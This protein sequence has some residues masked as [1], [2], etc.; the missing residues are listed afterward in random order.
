MKY[1][2]IREHQQE[3]S[4]LV[5]CRVLK[6]NRSGFYAWL[7]QQLSNRAIENS[8]LLARIK[9]F[10]V[11]SGG[12]YG[13]PW[14]HRDLRE[15][16]ESCSVNGVAKIMQ[17]SSLRAQIGYKC[18]YITGSKLSI[19]ADN[20]L[21][22]DF[23]PNR[24]NTVWVSDITYVRTYEGFLY[25]ATVIDLFSRRVVGWS[26]DKNMD[27][28][29]VIGALLMTVYQRRPRGPVLMHSD[30]GSQYGGSVYLLSWKSIT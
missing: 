29:L 26:M 25:L 12:T 6:I 13:S 18:G 30:Q 9:E 3:F 10:Y 4:V 21:E 27:K 16:V 5:M 17:Q 19:V 23:A 24:P 2:F 11:A 1:A 20:I 28:H 15:V 8:R 14:I 7:K 22:R